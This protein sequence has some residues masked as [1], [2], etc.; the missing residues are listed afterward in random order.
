MLPNIGPEF[1]EALLSR[2]PNERP[3]HTSHAASQSAPPRKGLDRLAPFRG[4]AFPVLS[5]I[6]TVVK[7]KWMVYLILMLIL[8]CL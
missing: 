7:I 8:I 4:F 6:L 1:V 5:R 3:T 2:A